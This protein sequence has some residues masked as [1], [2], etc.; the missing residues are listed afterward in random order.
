MPLNKAKIMKKGLDCPWSI[1]KIAEKK[2]EVGGGVEETIEREEG[3]RG[4]RNLSMYVDS[5]PSD[6][7]LR[8]E[9][10]I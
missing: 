9:S 10:G 4:N 1:L 8:R 3:E 7:L 2:E 5:Q 6:L